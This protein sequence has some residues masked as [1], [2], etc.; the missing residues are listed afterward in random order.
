MSEPGAQNP[1]AAR[2]RDV[3][4]RGL[5]AV[6]AALLKGD[7][8]AARGAAGEAADACARL[9]ELGVV[10][11]PATRANLAET[12]ARA[13]SLAGGILGRLGGELSGAARSRRAADAYGAPTSPHR[14]L[15]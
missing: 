10:L 12:C 1:E 3:L 8:E 14:D 4:A 7:A 11:D 2:L 15:P 6:L 9:S 13:E 5:E